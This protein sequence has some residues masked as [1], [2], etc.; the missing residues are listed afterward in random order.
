[1]LRA[2]KEAEAYDRE[3]SE[4]LRRQ[5]REEEDARRLALERQQSALQAAELEKARLG[6]EA[7]LTRL[8]QEAEALR[9]KREALA[10]VEAGD[11]TRAA[12]NRQ[13]KA[14]LELLETRQRILNELTPANVQARLVELLPDIAGKLPQPKELRSV[15]ING[16]GAAQDGQGVATLVA[17]M[18]ALT[19]ILKAEGAGKPQAQQSEPR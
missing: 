2:R 4:R 7:E 8:K 3:Q 14:E 1:M 9:L 17:Q 19:N 6:V 13:S 16:S 15:S 10:G 5:Q 11:V 18:L 12:A